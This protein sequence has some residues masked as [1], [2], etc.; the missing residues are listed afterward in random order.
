MNKFQVFIEYKIKKECIQVYESKM[1][2][3][4]KTLETLSICDFQWYVASDQPYLY[5]EMFTVPSF[6]QYEKI[7]KLRSDEEH[8]VFGRILQ[9]IDGGTKKFHCW[10]FE[11]KLLEEE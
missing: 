6:E 4:K 5:V 11:R 8:E 9:D 3:C 2:A 7:K 10:C 1:F